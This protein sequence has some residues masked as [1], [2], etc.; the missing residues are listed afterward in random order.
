MQGK[1]TLAGHPV[2]PMLVAF[3]IGC[4]VA[5]VVADLISISQGPAFWSPMAT[6][7]LL[8]GIVGALVAAFF[9][10]IDYISTPM[11]VSAKSVAAWHMTLNMA[12]IVIFGLACAVRFLDHASVAGYALTGLGIV[13]LAVSGWLGGDVAHRHLV[14]SS[15]E[16]VSDAREAA[17]RAALTPDE[18]AQR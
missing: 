12:L 5:A 16:D 10:F 7:L 9:G 4:F 14:G 8:F 1:A 13:V 17:D 15:E 18:R 2:H 11:T 6:W 3:P